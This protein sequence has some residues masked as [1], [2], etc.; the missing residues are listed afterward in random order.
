MKKKPTLARRS[1]ALLVGTALGS[2]AIPALAQRAT[3]ALEEIVVTAQRREQSLQEVPIAVTALT[4]EALETNRVLTVT[5]LSGLA[6]NVIVRPAAGGTNIPSF[7]VRGITSYGVVP[8]SDKQTSVYLDGVYIGANRGNIFQ[9]PDIAQI[10][11]L[12]GPQGTLFG[13]N[14]TAGAINITTRDP[15]GELGFRQDLGIGKRDHFRTRTTIE[16]PEWNGLSA[17]LSYA[18]EKRDGD[19]DNLASGIVWDRTL[20]GLG[21]AATPDT[22][23]ETD[24]ETWFFAL[25]LQPRED[26]TLKYKFDYS[27]DKGTPDGNGLSFINFPFLGAGAPLVQ[28]MLAANPQIA[29]TIVGTDTKRPDRLWN[30][31]TIPR[32]QEVEG[33]NLTVVWEPTDELTVKNILAYRE[34]YV[35]QP[36]GISGFD[37]VPADAVAGFLGLPPG[38][39]FCLVCSNSYTDGDQWSEE[40]Q[41]VWAGERLTLTLGALYYEDDYF[42]GSPPR[43]AGTQSFQFYP[44]GPNGVLILPGDVSYNLTEAKSYA[45]YGQ[46]EWRLDE[47]W[48]LILGGR[49]T[50]DEKEGLARTGNPPFQEVVDDY[51]KTKPNYLLG[52][53]FTPAENLLFFAK[54]STAF[55]SGGSTYGLAYDPEEAESWEL[56]MKGDFFAD[57]LRVNMTLFDVTYEN[58]QTAQSGRNVPGFETAGTL[59][60]PL[61]GDLDVWGVEAE[62]T[63]MPLDRLTLGLVLGYQDAEVQG[64]SD[65]IFRSVQGDLYPGSDYKQTLVPEWNGN[66]FLTWES[67]P[68]FG[69]AYL[70]FSATALWQDEMRLEPNP[71]RAAARPES[72]AFEF[73]DDAWTL[74]ARLALKEIRLGQFT[75]EVAFW[76]RNLTDNDE[77]NYTLN[78][79]G[80]SLTGYYPEARYYGV[81]F[82]LRY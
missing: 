19:V 45:A 26:L 60:V 67:K 80:L 31:Y 5:D 34:V 23:R 71:A 57:R 32:D 4:P 47:R 22:L 49:I 36:A 52:V 62:V 11:L 37:G 73:A 64:F 66:L 53:N 65:I 44:G 28:A 35:F 2:S 25:Q 51:K 29:A 82:S 16:T 59:V 14:A 8:G 20:I 10:E 72:R 41:A 9:L 77:V 33:H 12:R 75:G 70:S 15:S 74:N 61:G 69:D 68:L 76:G 46:A 42:S 39:Y 18:A 3:A 50:R 78:L 6:P 1:C 40:I 48:Q 7:T 27:E 54:Y 13:R 38:S 55:V 58:Y 21:R 43:G 30:G 81:D 17:Y 24:Q 79:G 63:A 56:G